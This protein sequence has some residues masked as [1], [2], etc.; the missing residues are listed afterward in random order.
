VTITMSRIPLS[1]CAVG[2]MACGGGDRRG[3]VLEGRV[4]LRTVPREELPGVWHHPVREPT[5]LHVLWAPKRPW[6]PEL[7]TLVPD[8]TCT[9]TPPLV[10]TWVECEAVAD[11]K[12]PSRTG[13][14]WSVQPRQDGEDVVI[15]FQPPDRQWQETRF[16]VFRHTGKKDVALL[17]T[18][19]MGDAYGLFRE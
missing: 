17:G 14:S 6:G 13:C 15:T 1:L 5:L 19:G 11:V 16:G 7:L 10:A 18:C 3:D 12:P 8:G 9:A 4:Y 2:M